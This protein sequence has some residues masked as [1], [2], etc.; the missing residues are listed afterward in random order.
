MYW[1]YFDLLKDNKKIDKSII[2]NEKRKKYVDA[3]TALVEM[4]Y[5]MPSY[6]ELIKEDKKKEQ[7]MFF[8]LSMKF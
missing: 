1:M 2:W 3:K 7:N 5:S 6:I 8:I 4:N